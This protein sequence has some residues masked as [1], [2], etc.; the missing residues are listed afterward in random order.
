MQ[1]TNISS[2]HTMSQQEQL[3]NKRIAKNTMFLYFRTLIVMVVG[4]YTS[5]VVLQ[6]LGVEDYGIYEVVGGFVSMFML[7]SGSLTVASQRFLAF[8]LGKEKSDVSK[9]FSST[10]TIHIALALI[11]FLIL[12]V[13][14]QFL[15]N[16]KINIPINRIQAANWVF[17]CS[18]I[19][20]CINIVS[21]PYN[22]AIVAYEKMS[23][24]A[25]V[26]IL[27]VT[28]KLLA[29]LALY[30]LNYDSLVLYAIFMMLI[31]FLL[32]LI[33]GW[34]CYIRFK[35]CR[36][37]FMMDKHILKTML[38][39]SGWN[40]IGSSA[41]VLNNQGINILTNLFFGV[42]LNAARG[43]ASQVN[44]AVNTFVS[45]FMM[46]LNPQIIKAFSSRN[47]DY[48]N[49]MIISGTK[50]A[51]FLFGIFC[52][53][54]FVNTEF[55]LEIWLKEVPNY[56]ALFIR[57]GFIFML[58][59]NLSQ[60]LYTAM[61]ATGKIKRYQIIVGGLSLLA[62]PVAW[63][64]FKAGLGCEWGYGA[65]II[66]SIVCLIARLFLLQEMVPGFNSWTFVRRSVIPIL[67]TTIPVVLISYLIHSKV[68]N[69]S[70]FSFCTESFVYCLLSILLTYLIGLSADEKDKLRKMIKNKIQNHAKK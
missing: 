45:N 24:F 44:N 35:E 9:V 67:L 52:L 66:F 48:L 11:L 23:A 4:L 46:A 20:F 51:Y 30:K 10:V 12:E 22:A 53:P 18:V 26:S 36:Y 55:I 68:S 15:L 63:M 32:Q 8:E 34:Y 59:Q 41:S 28:A 50:V 25:Y 31:A 14:G 1:T 6:V 58:L 64:F 47:Y 69:S 54:V 65:M 21:V 19:T 13:V 29:V 56:S 40:F 5:R 37:K 2:H 7:F 17:H 43:V 27:E 39:F 33:Y 42:T 16:H 3:N 70:V 60:C 62:F 38:C 61:L 49:K 57:L